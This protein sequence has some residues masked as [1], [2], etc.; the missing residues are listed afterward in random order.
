[1]SQRAPK[2]FISYAREDAEIARRIYRDLRALGARPW[3][4]TEDLLPGQKWSQEVGKA[5]RASDFF[6]ALLS[7]TALGK[8]GYIQKEL[9]EALSVLDEIPEG[10][11]YLLPVRL[12]ECRP[13][14]PK[15]EELHWVDLFPSYQTGFEK[16]LRV[17]RPPNMTPV[18][19]PMPLRNEDDADLGRRGWGIIFAAHSDPAIRDALRPLLELRRAQATHHD[20]RFYREFTGDTA[21]RA[22]D[23]YLQF[24][25]QNGV[26]P[27]VPDPGRIPYYLLIVSGP[28]TV[29]FEFQY[30]LAI[31]YRVGR[32][33]FD[34]T[35]EYRNYAQ[36]VV[37]VE[38]GGFR[39]S[40]RAAFFSTRHEGDASSRLAGDQLVTPL[41]ESTSLAFPDWKVRSVAGAQSTKL[42]LLSL[43]RGKDR[44]D[45]IFVVC[46]GVSFAPDD[47]LQAS[48]QGSLLCADWQGLGTPVHRKDYLSA[49]DI[50]ASGDLRGLQF[51]S[52]AEFGAG[53]PRKDD[54]AWSAAGGQSSKDLAARPFVSPLAKRLLGKPGGASALLAHVDRT[55]STSFSWQGAGPQIQ[56]FVNAVGAVLSGKPIGL[57]HRHFSARYAELSANLSSKLAAGGN[58]PS[59]LRQLWI[60]TMDARNYIVIGDPAARIPL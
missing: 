15:M 20:E 47:E 21:Y 19:V 27:G 11:I 41:F 8:R 51:I 30:D 14:N 54:F 59:E 10:S 34:S 1:M 35:D 28:E 56:T 2:V 57:A 38:T 43:L 18:G 60:A 32:I 42:E 23:S 53:T 40:R 29:P 4:D 39:T 17:V 50:D 24:L 13:D 16:I 25:A 46:H 52:F 31:Q 22:G 55:W 12:D 9:R 45:L 5:I 37:S 6:L 44:P 48:D 33:H 3:L 7:N 58:S 26:G 49:S 36:S